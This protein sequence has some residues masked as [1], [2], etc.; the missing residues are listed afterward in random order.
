MQNRVMVIRQM[1]DCQSVTL[2]TDILSVLGLYVEADALLSR[3]P[4][5]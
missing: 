5:G 4:R 3:Q 2:G 1:M